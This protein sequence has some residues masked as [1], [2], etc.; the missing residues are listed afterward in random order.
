MQRFRRY[1]GVPVLGY[2]EAVEFASVPPGDGLLMGP[3]LAVPKVLAKTGDTFQSLALFE[4]HEAFGAQV[5]CN[6]K[7]WK[8]GWSNYPSLAPLGEIP[9][10]KLNIFGGSI[11]LGHPFAATGGR[12]LLN[13]C[14]ALRSRGGGRALI[15]VCAAGGGA[16]A[17]IVSV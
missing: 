7:A 4:I 6:M 2:L 11:A 1:W 10:E 9:E 3:A 5:L 15:S 14:D 12:L 8:E 17:A 13:A 16:A